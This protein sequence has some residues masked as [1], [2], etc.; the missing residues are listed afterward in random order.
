M[1]TYQVRHDNGANHTYPD[2]Q[3]QELLLNLYGGGFTERQTRNAMLALGRLDDGEE[4][5]IGKW[6]I[7]KVSS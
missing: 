3:I 2:G 5:E 4:V 6:T 7:R 1:S